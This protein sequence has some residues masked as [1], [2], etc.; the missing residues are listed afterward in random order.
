MR[1]SKAVVRHRI[2]ILILTLLLMVPSV[3][4]MTATRVNYDMLTYGNTVLYRNDRSVRRTLR[5]ITSTQDTT[6]MF[7]RCFYSNLLFCFG[8]L[9]QKSAR[10]F[11]SYFLENF[12]L[13]PSL[14]RKK[15][16]RCLDRAAFCVM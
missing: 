14:P 13:L 11:C 4:G 16:A 2:P 5:N 8:N 3:I 15:A 12:C 10:K 6:R 9:V 7:S 1:F